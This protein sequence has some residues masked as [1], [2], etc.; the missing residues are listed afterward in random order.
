MDTIIVVDDDRTFTRLLKTVLEMEGYQTS[1]VLRPDDVIAT[2]QRVEPLLILM[3][4]HTGREDTLGVLQEIKA[5]KRLK[6]VPVV[7]TSGMDHT[8]ECLD[9]GA[10]AFLLK[11]FRPSELL[12]TIKN[13]I[14]V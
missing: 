11:P 2:A 7:M 3:D 1:I 4:V 12:T 8:K 13:L 6:E 10:E 14:K 9:A 5:E